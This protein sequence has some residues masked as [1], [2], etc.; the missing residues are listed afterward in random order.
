M[1]DKAQD[2]WTV[3]G[4]PLAAQRK[5]SKAAKAQGITLGK[6]V[7]Q[8]IEAALGQPSASPV[9]ED[10][11]VTRLEALEARVKALEHGMGQEGPQTVAEG[12]L[13]EPLAAAQE[14][15]GRPQKRRKWTEEDFA[16]LRTIAGRGGTQADACRELGR[17][18]SDVNKYWKTLGLPT[19]PRKGRVLG[20]RRM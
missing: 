8:A 4:V 9:S 18:S 20:Q 7:A 5:A 17:T 13:E 1:A 2:R 10:S 16:T 3:R 11:V 12:P 19:V 6:W 15:P 14:A